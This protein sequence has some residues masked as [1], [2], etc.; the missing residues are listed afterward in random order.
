[1]DYLLTHAFRFYFIFIFSQIFFL[2]KNSTRVK[3][4]I[5]SHYLGAT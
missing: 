3:I 4:V 2:K 1:M 5:L